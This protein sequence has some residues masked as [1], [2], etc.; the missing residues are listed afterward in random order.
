[1]QAPGPGAGRGTELQLLGDGGVAATE[2]TPA[3]LGLPGDGE[4]SQGCTAVK[5]WGGGA[6]GKWRHWLLQLQG[7]GDDREKWLKP[8]L[9][10]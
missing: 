6:K 9:R 4:Q 2:V 5:G 3:N 1:M 10:I 7:L 8:R